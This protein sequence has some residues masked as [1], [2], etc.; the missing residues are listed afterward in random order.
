MAC[1]AYTDGAQVGSL[2]RGCVLDAVEGDEKSC[3]QSF[4]AMLA[5]FI[6]TLVD[7][8]TKIGAKDCDKFL[9]LAQKA[10]TGVAPPVNIES[11]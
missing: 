5:G 7:A 4:K 8:F 10:P 2:V 6:Q 1:K 9:P 3:S 11:C